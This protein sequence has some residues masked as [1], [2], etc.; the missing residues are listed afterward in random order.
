MLPGRGVAL[1]TASRASFQKGVMAPSGPVAQ[2]VRCQQHQVSICSRCTFWGLLPPHPESEVWASAVCS[3][4]PFRRFWSTLKFDTV[5]VIFN[6][7]LSQNLWAMDIYKIIIFSPSKT[8][9]FLSFWKLTFSLIMHHES[10]SSVLNFCTFI[11]YVTAETE[12]YFENCNS[13]M[14]LL[15]PIH[16][17]LLQSYN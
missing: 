9:N 13:T 15:L 2:L 14:P 16:Q 17:I 12:S 6:L 10:R 7:Y 3:T 11:D 8:A 4:K 5:L 1:L